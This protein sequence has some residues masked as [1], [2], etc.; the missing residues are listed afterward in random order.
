MCKFAYEIVS[1]EALISVRFTVR[2]GW[3]PAHPCNLALDSPAHSEKF[4]NRKYSLSFA[5]LSFEF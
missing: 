5:L 2:K 1:D 4:R 3:K